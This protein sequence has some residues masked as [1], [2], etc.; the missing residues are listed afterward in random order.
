MT[1]LPAPRAVLFDWDS[2]L[3][4]NWGAI[5]RALEITFTAMGQEPWSEAEVRANAKRSMRDRFPELFGD[6]WEDAMRTFYAG[7][8]EVHLDTLRPLPGARDLLDALQESNVPMGVVSNKTGSYLRTEAAHLG[9]ER[10]FLRIVG[11]QDAVED[12]PSAA[13][14]HLALDGSGIAAAPDVWFV[15]DSAVDAACALAAGCTAVMVHPEMPHPE[16]LSAHPPALHVADCA[17]LLD[18]LAHMSHHRHGLR[19]SRASDP[20]EAG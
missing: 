13:P 15:G 2:T 10:Y 8:A 9:W 4:D 5:T 20:P 1:T 12:K 17:A 16:D 14:V 19:R 3:V 7:F 6:R 18:Q 11:A